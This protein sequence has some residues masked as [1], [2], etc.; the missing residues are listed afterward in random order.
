MMFGF[1][2]GLIGIIALICMIWVIFDV[3]TNNKR[4]SSLAKIIW[5]VL[6]VFFSIITAVVY[7]FIGKK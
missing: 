6:A 2:G 7:Y 1:S 4:M 5:T 3:W